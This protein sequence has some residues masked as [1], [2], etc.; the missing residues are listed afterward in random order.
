MTSLFVQFESLLGSGENELP[1]ENV[2][3]AAATEFLTPSLPPARKETP[4]RGKKRKE[5][6]DTQSA[7]A[8]RQVGSP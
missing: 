7:Y 4:A 1:L 5:M 8:K 2:R 3:G 6:E